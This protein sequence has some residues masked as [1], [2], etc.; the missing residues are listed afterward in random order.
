[1]EQK[2][3]FSIDPR[4]VGTVEEIGEGTSRVRLR[5]AAEMAADARGLVHGGFTFG[6]ADYAA[7]VAVNDP[8]VVLGTADVRF[9]AP[10]RVGQ[11]MVALAQIIETGGKK[12]VVSVRVEADGKPV[13][14]GTF[15]TFTLEGH[16]LDL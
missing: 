6:L 9:T 1:M 8:N 2:T 5:A 15:S 13:F 3:H 7:M 10:V 14:E 12:R 11:E 16:V 4:L